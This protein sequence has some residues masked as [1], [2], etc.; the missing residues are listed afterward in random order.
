MWLAP[1]LLKTLNLYSTNFLQEN[2]TSDDFSP[3]FCQTWKEYM[4]LIFPKDLQKI[5]RERRAPN[6]FYKTSRVIKTKSVKD[7]ENR[8]E[9]KQT[10][11]I[12]ITHE[13]RCKS[14]N[15]ILASRIKQYRNTILQNSQEELSS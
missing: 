6:F 10:P 7:I 5:K 8:Q 11:K 13:Y 2:P 12:N 9:S 3:E 4:A 1:F 15:K 14:L